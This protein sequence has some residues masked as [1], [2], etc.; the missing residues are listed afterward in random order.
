MLAIVWHPGWRFLKSPWINP[1]SRMGIEV[2]DLLNES[3]GV[4]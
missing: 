1:V 4:Y 2:S 3:E